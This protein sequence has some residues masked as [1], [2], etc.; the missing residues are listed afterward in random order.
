M[1]SSRIEI[2]ALETC[3]SHCF[4]PYVC[5]ATKQAFPCV[6]L[7]SLFLRFLTSGSDLQMW[8]VFSTAYNFLG[9]EL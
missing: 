8:G 7:C 1:Y 4:L 3:H 5:Q 6:I 9:N 2:V